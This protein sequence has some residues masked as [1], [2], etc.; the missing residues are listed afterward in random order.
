MRFLLSLLLVF[1][2]STSAV[3]AQ[4]DTEGLKIRV[5]GSDDVVAPTTPTL[6]ATAVSYDQVDVSWS[7]SYDNFLVSGYVLYRDGLPLSTTTQTSYSDIGLSASTTYTYSVRAFD[8]SN[9]YSSSS[10]LVAVLT[11][12]EPVEPEGDSVQSTSARV[13][14]N[15]LVVT[16]GVSTSTFYIKTARPAR[17]EMRWGKTDAYE[18]GYVVNQRLLDTHRTTLTDLEPGTTYYYEVIGY[19]PLGMATVLERGQFKTLDRLDVLVPVNVS[20]FTATALGNDV[21]LDWQSPQEDY[22]YVRIVRNHLGF[23]THAQD[24]VIIYQGKGDAYT[25]KDILLEYSPAY[26]TAFVVDRY[27]NVSSGAIAWAYAQNGREGSTESPVIPKDTEGGVVEPGTPEGVSVA[28]DP[29]LKGVAKMPDLSQ[30]LIVQS[31]GQFTFADAGLTL[32]SNQPFTISIPKEAITVNLK[33]I[34]A[35]ITDPTDSRKTYSFLLR[36]NKDQTAYEA[37]VAA[38]LVAGV[39]QV[40]IDVYD[41]KS[42][43]VGTYKKSIAFSVGKPATKDV[44]IFPDLI[45]KKGLPFVPFLLVPVFGL[46]LLM[47]YRRHKKTLS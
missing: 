44:P 21:D 36:I 5:F 32:D 31:G 7:A 28:I 17:F 8:P 24:G 6:A 40:T 45:I 16:P 41:Y 25:D 15:Q 3:F 13:V 47:F 33:T 4:S 26:Y 35:S 1:S 43:V 27:G 19:T 42:G 34:I 46:L 14:L 22:Q 23:P 18:L 11:P 39:S 20:R 29:V 30:I 37:S 38:L 12:A 9:N 2:V 10:N